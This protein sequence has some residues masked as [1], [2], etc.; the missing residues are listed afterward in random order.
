MKI[1]E[2]ARKQALEELEHEKFLKLVAE[3]KEKIKVKKPWYSLL[4]F[5]ISVK[6]K[7]R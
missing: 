7:W 6:I 5:T 1:E 3:Y 2:L 4:P